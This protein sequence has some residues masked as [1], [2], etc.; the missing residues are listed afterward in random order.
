MRL[1]GAA[2]SVLPLPFVFL[3]IATQSVRF[4]F[5]SALSFH[6][7]MQR[8]HD[9]TNCEL[10]TR[11]SDIVSYLRNNYRQILTQQLQKR[12]STMFFACNLIGG[13]EWMSNIV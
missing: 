11:L 13:Q 3:R 2:F 7:I 9:I 10:K 6:K 4:V 5:A 8:R 12:F 1:A